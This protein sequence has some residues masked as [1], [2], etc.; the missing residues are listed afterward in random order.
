MLGRGKA[1]SLIGGDDD[2]SACDHGAWVR[3]MIGAQK[4]VVM[5]ADPYRSRS[6]CIQL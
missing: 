6:E 1:I 4:P 5:S 2:E 3:T